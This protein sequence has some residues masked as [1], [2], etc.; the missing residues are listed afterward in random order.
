M[1]RKQKKSTKKEKIIEI[2]F[3]ALVDLLIGFL[4]IIIEKMM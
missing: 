1:S 3:S 4:L 2:L